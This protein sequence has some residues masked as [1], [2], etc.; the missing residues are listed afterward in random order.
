VGRQLALGHLLTG[1]RMTGAQAAALGLAYRA[2]DPTDFDDEVECVVSTMAG[3]RPDALR[4]IKRLVHD[5]LALSLEQGIALEQR[6][7]VAHIS[8]EA[9]GAGVST[10]AGRGAAQ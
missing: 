1:D 2:Y 7:V 4:T 5:G 10:F 8:G 9:G 6:S 3:R